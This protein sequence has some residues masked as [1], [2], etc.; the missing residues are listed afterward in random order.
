MGEHH[1]PNGNIDNID[2]YQN[3][4]TDIID[5]YQ[6][7]TMIFSNIKRDISNLCTKIPSET[8]SHWAPVTDEFGNPQFYHQCGMGQCGLR[9]VLKGHLRDPYISYGL[10]PQNVLDLV[11]EKTI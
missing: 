3:N 10:L 7:N 11:D 6:N 2:I 1:I 9:Y 8:I 5:I 4:N